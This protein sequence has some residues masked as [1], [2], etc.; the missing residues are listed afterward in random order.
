MAQGLLPPGQPFCPSAQLRRLKVMDHRGSRNKDVVLLRAPPVGAARGGGRSG[1]RNAGLRAA[2]GGSVNA[3]RRC[4][5]SCYERCNG[6]SRASPNPRGPAGARAPLAAP[7]PPPQDAISGAAPPRLA[8]PPRSS[9]SPR[10][11]RRASRL[12]AH[13]YVQPPLSILVAGRTARTQ[14]ALAGA[15][16]GRTDEG[17]DCGGRGGRGGGAISE[18]EAATPQPAPAFWP[19]SAGL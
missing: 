2:Q 11:G 4:A 9:S 6:V 14:A 18:S 17:R 15:R 10:G 1:E 7:A 5:A 8:P 16:A 13:T 19:P 12:L 3:R